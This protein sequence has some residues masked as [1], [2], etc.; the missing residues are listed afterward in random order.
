MIDPRTGGFGGLR[1]SNVAIS[2]Y[3]HDAVN[4]DQY[5]GRCGWILEL[6]S[7]I[8]NSPKESGCLWLMIGVFPMSDS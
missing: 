7:L 5:S 8:A 4:V 2:V 6:H 3:T 1:L